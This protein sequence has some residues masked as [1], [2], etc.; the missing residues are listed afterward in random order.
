M[1]LVMLT[2]LMSELF[3]LMEARV[4]T[5]HGGRS[6]CCCSCSGQACCGESFAG[7]GLDGRPRRCPKIFWDSRALRGACSRGELKQPS[8]L[9][10]F[11]DLYGT[12]GV[13]KASTSLQIFGQVVVPVA[14]SDALLLPSQP[15][16][17]LTV[18]LWMGWA[19]LGANAVTAHCQ[20]GGTLM[21]VM[22]LDMATLYT[23][24]ERLASDLVTLAWSF[25][26]LS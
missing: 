21:E 3:M 11:Q 2:D 26:L 10:S 12:V 1:A 23:P 17:L 19:P 7:R 14:A 4:M 15:V 25:H 18:M 8:G 16:P 5:A 6:W 20:I 22:G 13:A 24:A 9:G